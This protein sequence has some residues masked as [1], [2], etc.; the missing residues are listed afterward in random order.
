L[1]LN[2]F[3]N[4]IQSGLDAAGFIPVIGEAADL[5]SAGVS[6]AQGDYVGA[7]L[8][9]AAMLPIGGQAAGAAKLGRRLQ[10]NV[11]WVGNRIGVLKWNDKLALGDDAVAG[12]TNVG[13]DFS[14]INLKHIRQSTHH[15]AKNRSGDMGARASLDEILFQ[16]RN[17]AYHEAFH[18]AV[19]PMNGKMADIFGESSRTYQ[20][21]SRGEE[22]LAKAWGWAGATQRTVSRKIRKTVRQRANRK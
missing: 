18:R 14:S 10:K 4:W 6:L 12:L 8:S 11:E 22:Q 16:T 20:I 17:T 3:W 1:G 2:E 5:L 21:F 13:E 19:S 7:G 15:K 9:L